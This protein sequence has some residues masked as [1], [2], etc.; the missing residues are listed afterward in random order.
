MRIV[1]LAL[2]A[3]PT[4]AFI[5]PTTRPAHT[6]RRSNPW[7]P[8]APEAYYE[9][10]FTPPR[11]VVY[12]GPASAAAKALAGETRTHRC[13]SLFE[14]NA[15]ARRV[16]VASPAAAIATFKVTDSSVR[17]LDASRSVAP[18]DAA[19]AWVGD[20]SDVVAAAAKGAAAPVGGDA[21]RQKVWDDA[22]Q[23]LA[24]EEAA[25]AK[26]DVDRAWS[27]YLASLRVTEEL[28]VTIVGGEDGVRPCDL[29]N[30]KGYRTQF[31]DEFPCDWC[32]GTGIMRR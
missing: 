29:C 27:R 32:G 6:P 23:A 25:Q 15:L 17:L 3:L 13:A 10:R 12:E 26:T 30:G 20:F 11:D 18:A 19:D 21:D 7:D 16:M 1:A 24:E 4:G 5:H 22:L 31:G 14:A 2:A 9:V 8:P 28:D